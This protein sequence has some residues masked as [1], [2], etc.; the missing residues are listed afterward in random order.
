M[1]MMAQLEMWGIQSVFVF[2]N[3]LPFVEVFS[4]VRIFWSLL[5]QYEYTTHKVCFVRAGV[6]LEGSDWLSW[7][8]RQMRVV[9]LNGTQSKCLLSINKDD[10]QHP[11]SAK[12]LSPTMERTRM[13]S[14]R[15]GELWPLNETQCQP[16][17]LRKKKER[18]A[19]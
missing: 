9:L 5:C 14:E 4:M 18:D 16:Y 11:Q 8:G 10:T 15:K 7:T 13:W 6:F 12:Q 17:R 2:Q 3:S 1:G 19:H